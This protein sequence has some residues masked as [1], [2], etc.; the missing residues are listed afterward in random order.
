MSILADIVRSKAEEIVTA[1]RNRPL[2]EIRSACS[3]LAPTRDFRGAL[4]SGHP[5]I[6]AE[7]KRAS[8]SRGL[9]SGSFDPG[10]LAVEYEQAGASALSVLTD[11]RYFQGDPH[12]LEEAK[13]RTSLPILRKDFILDEY[14]LYES[15]ALGADAVLLIAAIHQLPVLQDLVHRSRELDLAVITEVHS[16]EE[17]EKALASGTEI[18]GVNNRDLADFSV[19]LEV[20]LRLRPLIPE[21]IT[22]VSESGI[23]SPN[24][25]HE[26]CAAGYHALLIGER[27]MT[28][29]DKHA[30]LR[31][32]VLSG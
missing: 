13:E 1:Q 27:L 9:L 12:H 28:A 29:D 19:S 21:H 10:R 3:E 15:R 11:R 32:F 22:T 5:S 4:R 14:Q 20:S 6:I 16:E 23:M 17:L 25:A 31:S 2:A 24:M 18:I 7:I 8:P 26:L 30:V